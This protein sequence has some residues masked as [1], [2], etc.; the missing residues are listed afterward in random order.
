MALISG[1]EILVAMLRRE[2][3][4]VV[5]GLPGVQIMDAI[6]AIYRDGAIRWISTRHEQTAAYMAYGYAR[7]TG[8]IGVAMVLPGPGA[9]NTTAAIGTAYTASTPVLLISGQIESFHLGYHRGVLHELDRQIDIFR[10][11]TKWSGRAAG[12]EDIP[13]LLGQALGHLRTG[14]PR[15]VEL[16]VPFDLWSQQADMSMPEVKINPP[17][18]PEPAIVD[19]AADLLR[20]AVR[21]L[22]V[23]G[24]GATGAGVATEIVR[25]AERLHAPVVMTTE[26]RGAIPPGHPLNAGNFT[27]WLNPAFAM[28]DVILAAGSRLRAS[29]NSSLEL[30]PEQQ[31]IR[32]EFGA[33]ELES[34]HRVDLDIK[35]DVRTSL[36]TLERALAGP[37]S[38][39][40]QAHEI[41]RIKEQNRARLQKAA[42]LQM[43]VI[44]AMRGTLPGDAII[45]ADITNL[46]YWSDIAC[47]V[48]RL[49]SYVDASYF[50]TLGFAFPTALGAKIGNPDR[51]VV[52]ICGDG[53]FPYASPELATAVQEG[54]NVIVLLFTDNAYGTVTGI[55]RRQFGGRYVGNRL[56]NPDYVKF[57]EAFGA[58]G[59]RLSSHEELGGKL[60]WALGAKLPVIIEVPVPPLET[61][62]DTLLSKSG[63]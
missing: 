2:G 1:A 20:R 24:S 43:A 56:H 53:G 8:K 28:A 51:P 16:E 18:L 54:I 63:S 41:S 25:L 11:I 19:K 12:V 27:L 14:R 21:P 30:R 26:G 61:P 44:D 45:V 4:E 59:I 60:K 50:A 5:F 3:V 34:R 6:D 58:I 9:L 37:V 35:A 32:V 57:A 48:E 17:L 42:P 13:A 52:V 49:R 7:T 31:L 47:P 36:A 29:G 33:D 40:W 38:S 22:I 55:Q 23:A 39:R 62:W 15:P 46:G 10:Q